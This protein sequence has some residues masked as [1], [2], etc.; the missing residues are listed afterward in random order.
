MTFSGWTS[1]LFLGLQ[2][3]VQAF[4]IAAA[5]HHAA[6]EFV[7]DD[8]LVVLD[9]V[10]LV[11]L[12]Q[13]VRLQ[14]LIDVMDDGDVLDVVQIARFEQAGGRAAVRPYARCRLRSASPGAAFR[15]VRNRPWPSCGHQS[16]RPLRYI[17]VRS[18]VG[19]EM[20]SGVR[21]SSIR[22]ESTSSTMA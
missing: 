16:H 8:D 19:P 12:E 14:R 17:S 10:I 3:L 22:M 13:L 9:D 1:T 7:D 4:G 2:R 18:S 20:I 5:F 21:A 15:R 11:L 6:G